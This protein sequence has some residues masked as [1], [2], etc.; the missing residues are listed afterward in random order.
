MHNMS[1]EAT[2][3]TEY[4]ERILLWYPNGLLGGK[5]IASFLGVLD[6]YCL[7]SDKFQDVRHWFA[8]LESVS[9]V[10]I[11]DLTAPIIIGH[12]YGSWNY[13]EEEY[14]RFSVWAAAMPLSEEEFK[15]TLRQLANTWVPAE[16]MLDMATILVDLLT[17]TDLEATWWYDPEDTLADF[18]ALR[19]AV[20]IA[21]RGPECKLRIQFL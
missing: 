3:E 8:R 13:T 7:G 20:A 11:C 5:A 19:E 14:E 4:G 1:V 17:K 21:N 15:Q 12:Y 16:E 9:G 10:S 18:R 2:I 6:L